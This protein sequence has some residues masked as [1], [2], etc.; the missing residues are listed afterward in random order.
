MMM[1]MPARS[2]ARIAAALLGG[3]GFAFAGSLQAMPMASDWMVVGT[4]SG[5]RLLVELPGR[6]DRDDR[7]GCQGGCHATCRRDGELIGEDETA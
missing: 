7:H 2:P 3:V 6:P 4:C 5:H 1:S